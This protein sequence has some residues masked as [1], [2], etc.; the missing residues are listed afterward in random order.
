MTAFRMSTFFGK[1]I[2]ICAF[3]CALLSFLIQT[4][5]TFSAYFQY[6]TIIEMQLKFKAGRFP[7]FENIFK[8]LFFSPLSRS[9][10]MQ[11]EPLQVQ[12]TGH[13]S[14]DQRGGDLKIK[15]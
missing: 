12:R 11:F 9:Y 7:I 6:R 15:K 8:I 14:G 13:V 2:W 4:Y 5:W 10:G 3:S 1:T